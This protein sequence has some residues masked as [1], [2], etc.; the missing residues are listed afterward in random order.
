M[1]TK[2]R[3]RLKNKEKKNT[4]FFITSMIIFCLVLFSG[5]VCVNNAMSDLLTMDN[6][7]KIKISLKPFEIS[8]KT[9]KYFIYI[10]SKAKDNYI[11]FINKI[12]GYEN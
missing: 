1:R 3:E 9:Q 2:I 7:P 4:K 10:D 6:N 8:V 5:F 12:I 11:N